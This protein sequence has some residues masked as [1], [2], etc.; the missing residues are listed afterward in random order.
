MRQGDVGLLKRGSGSVKS[1]SSFSKGFMTLGFRASV[2]DDIALAIEA[3]DEH[4]ASVHIAPRLVG[5][6]DRGVIALGGDVADAFAEAASA[7]LVGAAEVIDRVIGVEGSNAGFHG[8][9]MLVAEG[10][11]V[12]A[13]ERGRIAEE[14]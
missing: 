7:E 9:E 5:S 10:K 6:E 1:A 4:G 11:K 2:A 12:S 14:Q 13:H 3:D 8:A